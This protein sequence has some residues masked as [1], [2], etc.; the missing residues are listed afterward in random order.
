MNEKVEFKL[1]LNYSMLQ[2]CPS[3]YELTAMNENRLNNFKID[4]NIITATK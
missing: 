3:Y 2:Y 1:K 4:P